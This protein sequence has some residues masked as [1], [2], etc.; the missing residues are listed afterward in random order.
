MQQRIYL[1]YQASTPVD[2][3][4]LEAMTP[5]FQ[6]RP[7]NPHSSEHSFGWE[8][9]EAV[10]SAASQVAGGLGVDPDEIVF[11]SGATEANN[12]AIVGA[13]CRASDKRRRIIVSAI[14]HKSVLAT[15]DA[16]ARR[17]GCEI[18]ALPV[19][20]EGRV[21]LDELEARL[22]D[23]VLLVSVM[24]VNNEI[25]SVQPIDTIAALA[26]EV[27]ALVHTDGAQ[28]LTCSAF[29]CAV[30]DVDFA[31]LSGH[32][33][34]GPKGV[35]ALYVKRSQRG[36]LE[37]QLYGGGQQGGLRSGTL[38]VPLI[39]GFGRAIELLQGEN[40]D[41]ERK[42]VR[43]LRNAFVARLR[44]LVPGAQVN[45][46]DEIRRHPGNANI[47]FREVEGDVLVGNMQPTIGAST[48]SACNAGSI[49]PS[50]VLRAIGLSASEANSSVRFSIGRFSTQ[51]ELDQACELIGR[52]VTSLA[53]Q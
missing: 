1:D 31:S 23:D 2:P 19:D 3:R 12:L 51:A 29:D 50:H 9:A 30:L 37:P 39:V 34:Y 46:P 38:P 41:T 5:Y 4:V 24:A 6:L 22:S 15:V 25:G 7:G 52:A 40:A 21:V 28:A 8:A 49:E 35:G 26:H 10:E 42:R 20:S 48:G 11:T 17:Y 16:V 36:R 13:V 47:R 18:D 27:G 53:A 33:V 45:G 14:E 32:K 43:E 44:E